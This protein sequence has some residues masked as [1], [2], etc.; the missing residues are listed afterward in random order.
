MSASAPSPVPASWSVCEA[1]AVDRRQSPQRSRH[2]ARSSAVAR[3]K[4][5][6]RS[7]RAVDDPPPT[8]TEFVAVGSIDELLDQLLAEAAV[9]SEAIV[10]NEGQRQAIVERI[11][12]IWAAARPAWRQP[13]PT[14]CSSSTGRSPCCTPASTAVVRPMPTRPTTTSSSSSPPFRRGCVRRRRVHRRRRRAGP[15][16]ARRGRSSGVGSG[17]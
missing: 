7:P 8:T 2:G 4:S 10:P 14:S 1:G 6:L 12:V 15:A 17:G 5:I 11:D 16:V 3:P 9:L 13:R